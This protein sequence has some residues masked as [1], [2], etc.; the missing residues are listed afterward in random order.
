MGENEYM[1]LSC[2]ICTYVRVCVGGCVCACGAA[3]VEVIFGKDS[4][5][6]LAVSAHRLRQHAN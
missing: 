5:S 4:L 3:C 1:S 6:C 2:V